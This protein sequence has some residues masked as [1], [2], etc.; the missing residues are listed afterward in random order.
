MSSAKYLDK[1][2]DKCTFDK[3]VGKVGTTFRTACTWSLSAG[4]TAWKKKINAVAV[5]LETRICCS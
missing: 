5:D 4:L 2:L 1:C 3:N